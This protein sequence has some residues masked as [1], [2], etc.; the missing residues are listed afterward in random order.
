MYGLAVIEVMTM[1]RHLSNIDEISIMKEVKIIGTA[2]N[3]N[4]LKGI[5]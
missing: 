2:N 4:V 3:S 5:L 1:L